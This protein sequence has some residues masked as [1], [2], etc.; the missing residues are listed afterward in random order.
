MNRS[1]PDKNR[2][3]AAEP[4][5]QPLSAKEPAS[6]P[7]PTPPAQQTYT[8]VAGDTLSEIGE[9]FGVDYLRIAEANQ[10]ANPD[11]IQI[12]QVLVIPQ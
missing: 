9:R 7:E 10:I 5:L 4:S 6:A 2:R 12:G 3:R 1:V 11:L 8:V